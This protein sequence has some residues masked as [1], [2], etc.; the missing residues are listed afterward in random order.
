MNHT[1]G[2]LRGRDGEGGR[3]AT[4]ARAWGAMALAGLILAF[5]VAGPGAQ[6]APIPH[7]IIS[8]VPAVTE[9]LFAIGAGPQVIAV[10][11]FDRA[12]EAASLPRVGALLDPDM[13]RMFS[14]RPDLVILY[15]SQVDQQAQIRRAAIPMFSYRH[16]G[17]AD[18]TALIRD[19]GDR[20]GRSDTARD[21]AG[22]IDQELAAVR[23]RVEH[24]T[25]PRTLLVFGREP[26]A[27]RN[28]YASGGV[29]FLHD[30]LEAAG[31]KNVFADVLREAA[32]PTSETILATAPEVIIELRADG[33]TENEITRET[34]TW[35]QLSTVPAVRSARIHLLTG[36][37]L[38]VPGPRVAE[39]TRRLARLLHPDAF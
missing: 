38:V 4:S 15:G 18:V 5:H 37:E 1:V 10:S 17:L 16:G 14:L 22:A 30:M 24:R 31:G 26:D 11:S 28:V 9:I 12:G 13:E 20:T 7:R 2:N 36:N 23:E 34:D 25:R 27:I 21:V 19:L 6:P 8:V 35:Q 29:G 32:H 3:R 39:V 33:A